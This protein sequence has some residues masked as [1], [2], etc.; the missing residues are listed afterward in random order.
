MHRLSLPLA[1]LLLLAAAG[2]R[3]SAYS[4]AAKADTIEAYRAFLRANPKDD[5]A[6][7]AQARLEELEFIEASRLH[8]VVAYK[9]YLEEFP[10]SPKVRAAQALLEGLRFNAAKGQASSQ[11]LRRFLKDH[12]DGAHREEAEKLLTEAEFKEVST[13]TDQDRLARIVADHPDDPRR[14]DAEARLDDQAFRVAA[15]S[16]ASKLLGYLRDFPAGVHRQEAKARLFSLKLDGLLT[17][18][19]L[20]E[21]RQEAARSPLSA[22]LADLPARFERA[23]AERAALGSKEPA[24]QSAQAGNYLRSVEDLEKSLAAPDPLDRWQAAEELG[25]HVSVRAIDPL[26][27]AF[28]SSRSALVRQRA[29]ESLGAVLSA[30]PRRVA[31]YEVSIRLEAMRPNASDA[32]VYLPVAALLDLS[33]QLEAAATEYQRA[34]D[35]SSPDPVVLRRWAQIRRERRQFFSAAVAARQLALWALSA[36]R[37]EEGTNGLAASRQLCAAVQASRFALEVISEARLQKTEFPEDLEEFEARAQE[38]GKLSGARLKDA[39][40][41]LKTQDPNARGCEDRRVADRLAEAERTRTEA[42]QQVSAKLPKLAPLLLSVAAE[43]DPSPAV[44]AEA[45]RLVAARPR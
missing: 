41:L 13:L 31:D 21:A 32:A 7:P 19:L 14:A 36:A 29:F 17:S 39:E 5:L 25:Q 33:G 34:F 27:N 38:A 28:R 10:E 20:D 26:L 12:P 43:R 22:G 23:S 2:C 44:R 4:A 3:S 40:L 11:G 30:L 1:V 37:D 16:G 18:G 9:R 8:T 42:L 6:E 15:A 35:P 24:A 45:A